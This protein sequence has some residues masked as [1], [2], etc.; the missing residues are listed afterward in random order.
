[1]IDGLS[2]HIIFEMIVWDV[3]SMTLYDT[4]SISS[5][6]ATEPDDNF[7]EKIIKINPE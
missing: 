7:E 4:S 2:T 3:R 5:C 1:M 6:I